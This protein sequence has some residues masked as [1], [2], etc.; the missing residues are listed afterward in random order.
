MNPMAVCKEPRNASEESSKQ[1]SQTAGSRTEPAINS[2]HPLCFA[3][4]FS[5]NLTIHTTY[6]HDMTERNQIYPSQVSKFVISGSGGNSVQGLQPRLVRVV[7]LKSQM[8]E[9]EVASREAI[10]DE[11]LVADGV[12]SFVRNRRVGCTSLCC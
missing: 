1:Q 10:G 3:D 12:V 4:N 2:T 8:G 5:I 11:V 6:L 9:D 7:V